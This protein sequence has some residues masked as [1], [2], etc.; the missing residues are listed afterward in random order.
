MT[1]DPSAVLQI[2][3]T[4]TVISVLW[5]NGILEENIPSVN[6]RA[7]EHPGAFDFWPGLIVARAGDDT[8]P[9]NGPAGTPAENQEQAP[10][11][12][13]SVPAR[14]L[15]RPDALGN[16][17]FPAQQSHS[18]T[19][20]G[21]VVRSLLSERTAVVRWQ[22][23]N[24]REYYAEEEEVSFYDLKALA[25]YDMQLGDTV[26]LVSRDP[27]LQSGASGEPRWVGEIVGKGIGD[28]RVRWLGGD[29]TTVTPDEIIVV[30]DSDEE[31]EDDEEESEY[32]GV[33]EEEGI[34]TAQAMNDPAFRQNWEITDYEPSQISAAVNDELEDVFRNSSTYRVGLPLKLSDDSRNI[35]DIV[36]DITATVTTDYA[37]IQQRQSLTRFHATQL[38]HSVG[39]RVLAASVPQEPVNADVSE[40]NGPHPSWTSAKE[41]IRDIIVQAV[42]DSHNATNT[43]SESPESAVESDAVA[44]SED[45]NME[46]KTSGD[47]S[48]VEDKVTSSDNAGPSEEED[49]DI[50]RFEVVEKF[51]NHFFEPRS[52][53]VT[54][55]AHRPGFASIVMK[56]YSRLGR[57]LP[58]GIYVRGSESQQD[59]LRAAIVG[60][61][62]T[63]YENVLFYFDIFLPMMYP[64]EPPKVHFWSHGRRLNPNLYEDGKV[65]LSILGTWAG[66]DVEQWDARNSNVLRGAVE[67][68]SHGF[69]GAALLQ[70]S[71]VREADG[72]C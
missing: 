51:E 62:D 40:E 27:S 49:L 70:R 10:Y 43:R 7:N 23:P 36:A 5:Q 47:S 25:D 2:V 63:P 45:M 72:N 28:I 71:R 32:D 29:E 54:G 26:L 11:V 65:C 38:A 42:A 13:G 66:D 37:P 41:R 44:E 53:S 61:P 64:S 14:D 56:E 67:P 15:Q 17:Q 57:N 30:S 24:S 59:L 68:S 4:R 18:N 19:S 34:E 50:A 22:K 39:V 35:G 20:T 3:S 60:P 48:E 6:L 12:G 9:A 46:N 52:S 31:T 58:S 16:D 8:E 21:I 1:S 33:G 69:C 55:Q